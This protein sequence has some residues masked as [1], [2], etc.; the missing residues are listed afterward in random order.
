MQYIQ[1]ILPR[2][3]THGINNQEAQRYKT[4]DKDG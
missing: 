1:E 4:A 2:A 3:V